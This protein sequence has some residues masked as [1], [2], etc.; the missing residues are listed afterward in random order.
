MAQMNLQITEVFERNLERFMRVRNLKNRSEAVRQAVAE[1]ADRA[2]RTMT[3]A[4][5]VGYLKPAL[6]AGARIPTDDEIWADAPLPPA[7]PDGP[8]Y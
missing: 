6:D 3:W 5:A 1:A 4:D 7:W 8:R 2:E